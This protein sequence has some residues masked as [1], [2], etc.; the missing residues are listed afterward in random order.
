MKPKTLSLYKRI[1]IDV[2]MYAILV[3]SLFPIAWMVITSLKSNY[4]ILLGKVNFSQKTNGIESFYQDKGQLI[5]TSKDGFIARMDGQKFPKITPYKAILDTKKEAVSSIQKDPNTL[6]MV[7]ATNVYSIKKDT[8]KVTEL[9]K[10]K[11]V[12]WSIIRKV[13]SSV[14]ESDGTN[15]YLGKVLMKSV[16]DEDRKY[17]SQKQFEGLIVFDKN[18]KY[19]RT[20]QDKSLILDK[21]ITALKMVGN[22]LYIG[23]PEGL[24]VYNPKTNEVVASYTKT[25]TPGIENVRSILVDS[26]H[27]TVW[28]A[29]A[30]SIFSSKFNG[31][32]LVSLALPFEPSEIQTIEQQN[33]ALYIGTIN[34]LYIY[35][36]QTKNLGCFYKD[37]PKYWNITKI[38]LTKDHIYLG[39]DDGKI[40][41]LENN[42]SLLLTSSAAIRKG[43]Y[44]IRWENYIDMW[45]NISFGTYLKNS[46]IICVITVFVAL[47]MAT[48]AGYALSRFKF[49]GDSAFSTSILAVNM[50]PAT[51]ILI[52]IYLMYIKFDELTGIRLVGT[53]PGIIALYATWFIPMSIWIL[54]SFFAAIPVEIEEAARIDGCNRFQVF[55]KI[56][57]PLA[58]PGIIATGIYIFLV[59]W[60][61]LLFATILLPQKEMLT[62]PLGI[63]LYIGNHQ[64]RFDLMMAAATV[65]TLPVLILFFAV[66]RWFIKGLTAG[67]VKG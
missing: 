67:A 52:P 43:S 48:S 13:R 66:Q 37:Q 25:N 46:V 36:L 12:P 8:R 61:E 15:Y 11:D 3:V 47:L 42:E 44:D 55:W 24:S 20:I 17:A 14:I 65:A 35:Y 60:D 57:L 7:S 30:K 50:I 6:I 58:M 64:N 29:T 4:D 32:Q 10:F 53:Y 16:E 33:D 23:S 22:L 59:A 31:E 54:R 2:L 45:S 40:K 27:Q 56:A 21:N 28:I 63:K 38:L 39:L 19:L 1:V 18:F 62:I 49:K 51:L 9:Y 41:I 5:F 34:G 26:R